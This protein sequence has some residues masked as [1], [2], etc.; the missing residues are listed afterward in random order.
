[1]ETEVCC[2]YLS[3]FVSFE[4]LKVLIQ[5]VGVILMKYGCKMVK[6]DSFFGKFP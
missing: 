2:G 5:V 1:M 3:G 4:F 6:S